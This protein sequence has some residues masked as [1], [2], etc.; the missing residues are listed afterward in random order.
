MASN[1]NG[2]LIV[3]AITQMQQLQF[4]Y[5][6]KLRI[7]EPQFYGVGKKGIEQLRGYQVNEMPRLEKLFDVAKMENVEVLPIHFDKP[8]PNYNRY[9]S[10]F[11]KEIC[12]LK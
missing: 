3:E 4:I 10:A 11:V 8:G 12:K 6:D 2:I 5:N 7:V 1:K 9:D